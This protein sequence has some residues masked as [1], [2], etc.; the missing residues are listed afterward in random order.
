MSRNTKTMTSDAGSAAVKEAASGAAVTASV[1]NG[2]R[3]IDLCYI[4]LSVALI[5][6]CA[7]ITIPAQVSFTMQTFAVF[8][9]S[10]LLGG[11]RSVLAVLV[12]ILLG[13]VGV[14]VFSGMKGG[15]P[16]LLG[17]TGGYIVGFIFIALF[18]WLFELFAKG[19]RWVTALSMLPGLLICYAF[20]T[21]WFVQVYVGQDGSRMGYAA[22][23]SVCVLPFIIPD[24]L[25]AALAIAIGSNKA[26]RRAVHNS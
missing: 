25:K 7:W 13:A 21:V 26:L 23:L 3:I 2:F 9:T 1:N 6:V 10:Y 12:Y 17:P 5:S 8:L 16:V 4:A 22:A 18:M 11:R 24:L 20:G 14:P 19:R 15:L